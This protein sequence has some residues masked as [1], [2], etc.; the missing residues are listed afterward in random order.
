MSKQR[1]KKLNGRARAYANH[2]IANHSS[3]WDNAYE[4]YQDGYRA[5]MRDMRKAIDY[6]LYDDR[7]VAAAV[8][9]FLRPLR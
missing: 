1:K 6:P 7:D 2:R 4:G 3:P 8:K 9:K 5:A